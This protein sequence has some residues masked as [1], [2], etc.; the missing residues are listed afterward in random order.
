[1]VD[2]KKIDKKEFFKPQENGRKIRE[3]FEDIYDKI[4]ILNER[5]KLLED[6]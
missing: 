5:L 3:T 4:D 6:K 1:M 2:I